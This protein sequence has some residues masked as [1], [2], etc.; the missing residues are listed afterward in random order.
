MS[1]PFKAAMKETL[2]QLI[3]TSSSAEGASAKV[4]P[5][6]GFWFLHAAM[7]FMKDI[8]DP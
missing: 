5:Q 3:K 7:F 4:I 8:S 6:S 1:L 2:K